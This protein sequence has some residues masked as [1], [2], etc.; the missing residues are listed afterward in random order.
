MNTTY[1]LTQAANNLFRTTQSPS[2]IPY[3]LGLSSTLPNLDGTGVTEP[4][5]FTGYKRVR[6]TNLGNAVDGTVTNT[7]K[8]DF[9]KSTSYW[10]T[11]SFFV[12]FD[13]PTGG[14]LLMYGSLQEPC[15]VNMTNIVTVRPGSLKLSVVNP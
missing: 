13:A 10:G 3:Y 1:F 12:V 15:T 14:N 4:A 5:G 9:D 7:K 11:L 2:A 6:L 8:I